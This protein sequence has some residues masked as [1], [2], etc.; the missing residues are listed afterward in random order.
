MT[1]ETPWTNRRFRHF[2]L[3]ARRFAEDM[4]AHDN[5]KIF[6]NSEMVKIKDIKINLYQGDKFFAGIFMEDPSAWRQE[7]FKVLWIL[8]KLGQTRV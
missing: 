4:L 6:L 2:Q 8:I 5:G 7:R 3:I 1:P